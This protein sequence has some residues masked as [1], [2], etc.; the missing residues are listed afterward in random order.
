MSASFLRAIE[1]L[2]PSVLARFE[3]K[4][5]EDEKFTM[6]AALKFKGSEEDL[7]ETL[8]GLEKLFEDLKKLPKKPVIVLDEANKIMKWRESDP[9]NPQLEALFDFLIQVSKQLNLVHVILAT[10]D[11]FLVGWLAGNGLTEDKFK[12][13]VLGELPEKE[14]RDFVFGGAE[15][16]WPEYA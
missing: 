13:K 1:K 14:A 12:R 15:G 4:V 3:K 9:S 11:Y 5:D 16:T 8:A 10:S 6:E 2:D 7:K